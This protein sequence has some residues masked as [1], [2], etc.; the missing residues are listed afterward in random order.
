MPVY[1][2][3]IRVDGRVVWRIE[4]ENENKALQT[5]EQ[6]MICSDFGPLEDIQWEQAGDI[7]EIDD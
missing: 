4:A 7:Y 3:T 2:V 6:G 5:A 1:E